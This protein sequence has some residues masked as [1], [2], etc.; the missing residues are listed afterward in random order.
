LI[1]GT[2]VET[3]T[4]KTAPMMSAALVIVRALVER[5][6]ATARRVSPVALNRSRMR[7]GRNAS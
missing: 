5:P 1:D 3:N 2:P 6:S 7:L 4:A